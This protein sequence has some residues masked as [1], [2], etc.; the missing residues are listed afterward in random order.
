MKPFYRSKKNFNFFSHPKVRCGDYAYQK[1]VLLTLLAFLTVSFWSYYSSSKEQKQGANASKVSK[2]TKYA[3]RVTVNPVRTELGSE[4]TPVLGRFISRRSGYVTTKVSGAVDNLKRMVGDTVKAG[5]TIANLL[6]DRFIWK[7]NLQLAEVSNFK[8]Q[9]KTREAQINLLL[10]E[11]RRLI[12]LKKSPAFS[13]ARLD[14]KN[15]EILVAKSQ[16]AEAKAK[17]RRAQAN[18]KLTEIDLVDAKIKAP[19]SGIITKKHTEEG[20][21]LTIGAKVVSLLSNKNLE[22]EV[23]IP[24]YQVNSLK[25]KLLVKG[26]FGRSNSIS[27]VLRA[28]IPEENPQTGTRPAIFTPINLSPQN[29]LAVNQ[30][31]TLFLPK[32]TSNK[33]LTVHKDAV[34]PRQGR[35]LV[36]I[37][38]ED[39]AIF[40]DVVL[41]EAIGNRFIVVK[42]LID[43]DLT[44]IRGNER[45][46][47]NQT[48]IINDANKY[49]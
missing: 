47:P 27:A 44:I 1:K 8:A 16:L 17:L 14:D 15:Q 46:Q 29:L 25:S 21:Y 41:G 23:N 39:R 35:Y 43:G 7:K 2:S 33:V 22:I 4:T 9:A 38:K 42:G 26:V 5:D 31:V 3:P 11:R 34:L 18:L 30:S 45:L 48:V 28:I 37:A 36:I 40:R 19:Y 12:S 32:V 10:S 13:Q 49:E 20:A 24:F 6:S